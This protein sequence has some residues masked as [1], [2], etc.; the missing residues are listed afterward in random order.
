MM[1]RY[2]MTAISLLFSI[3]LVEAWAYDVIV[4]DSATHVPL[5]NASIYD[6]DGTP[7]GLS[8]SN[9]AVPKITRNR[10]PIT[11]RY[12]GFNDKTVMF[13][14]KDT[15]F[16]S[17]KVSELPEVIVKSSRQRL[18]HILAYVREYS[19]LATYT[20]TIFLFREKMVDYMLPS[21]NKI[22]FKGWTY[23]RVLTCKSY[24]RFTNYNG[25][26][27]VSDVGQ[28]HFSWSDWIGMPPEVSIPLRIRNSQ[29]SAD[30]LCGKYS[31]TEIW[32]KSNDQIRVDVD[33]LADTV[34]RKW[35]PSLA[36]FF[37]RGLDYEKFKVT[38][39]YDNVMGDSISKLDLEGYSFSIESKGRGR[40]MFRFN[41][42][43]EPFFVST[44]ADVY[45]LD[46][47]Y[48]TVKE[49]KEWDKRDFDVDEI[50]I[51][52]P[53]EAPALSISTLNLIERVNLLDKDKIR[54]DFLPDHRLM[55]SN[56]G[57]RNFRIGRR[58]LFLLKQVTG[59]TLYK[60]HK[61]FNNNWNSFRKKQ[62]RRNKQSADED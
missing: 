16:L 22:K 48:I 37:R 21:Y 52:E 9:G 6:K 7:V 4:V 31:P 61:N 40:E 18:L 58:A 11:V 13:G 17:E 20:D 46:K 36:N 43:D 2:V 8:N 5:P 39:N 12:L 47:E 49:A 26:D 35:V 34:S 24:Y 28:H 1:I 56:S 55:G 38:F 19:T 15:I 45:I 42:I 41:K 10:Y 51:Y 50:G 62:I 27:S 59:I 54:L 53:L 32:H 14:D 3:I 23:P 25:L 29:I 30:T 44:N 33:V 60:S 57:R